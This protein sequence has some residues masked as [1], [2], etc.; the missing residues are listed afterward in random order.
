MLLKSQNSNE[1]ELGLKTRTR[2]KGQSSK[3]SK[4]PKLAGNCFHNRFQVLRLSV[5]GTPSE[6]KAGSPRLK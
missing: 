3:L 6:S 1:L 5:L 4:L 2:T